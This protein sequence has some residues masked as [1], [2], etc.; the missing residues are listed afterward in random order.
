MHIRIITPLAFV[1]ML[2]AASAPADA[3]GERSLTLKEALSLAEKGNPEILASSESV[4]A[5]KEDIGI[6]R[7]FLLPKITFEERFMR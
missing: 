5:T 2:L 4:L 1:L 7:S 6:A 3:E